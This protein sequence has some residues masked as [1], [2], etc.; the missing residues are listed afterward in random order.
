[1]I[2]VDESGAPVAEPDLRAGRVEER[3]LAVTVSWV[4]DEPEVGHE[5]VVAEYPETGGRDVAWVV[6]R[7]E[8]GRWVASDPEGRPVGL[9]D[10]EVPPDWPRETPMAEVWRY[11]CYLPWTEE[12]LAEA[13]A[14]RLEA[15]E[16]AR[17]ADE[18]EAWL[19]R[20]PGELD[21]AQQALAELGAM[22]DGTAVTMEEV[23]DAVAELGSLLAASMEGE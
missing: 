10:G 20:A 13:E 7:P 5:E 12:E 8:R 15:E 4:V 14:A 18:R 11:G 22:A 9:W 23:L 16:A 19:S 1:M 2:V 6:D 21:D 3:A 17:A